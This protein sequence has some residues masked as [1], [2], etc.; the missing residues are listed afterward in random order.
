[1]AD[2]SSQLLLQALSRAAAESAAVP[3]FAGRGNPGL[4][5]ATQAGKQAA[6]RCREEGYLEDAGASHCT[7]TDKGRAYL[8]DHASPRQVLED[9]VRVLEAREAQAAQLVT[10]ARQIQA[11]LEAM[12]HQVAPVLAQA[13]A[14]PLNGLFRD[15]HDD[16]EPA[17]PAPAV[18]EALARWSA[19]GP[20]GD[21]PL[22]EL[23]RRTRAARPALTVGSFHDALRRLETEGAVA[24]HPWTGPL[25]AIPEPPYALLAGHAV[26]YYA[27]LRRRN[28]E[29][30]RMNLDTSGG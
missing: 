17:D 5:P 6:Q 26:A 18:A 27:S 20:A 30:R 29:G 9:F 16:P 24:L 28:D 23:F 8:L 25:Y 22:P 14:G 2:R 4:F 15:F 13:A 3:L 11:T 21:C 10:Q 7:L 12:R 19:S 1:M